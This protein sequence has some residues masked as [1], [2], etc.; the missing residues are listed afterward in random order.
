[1][2]DRD[3]DV[4]VGRRLCEVVSRDDGH[5]SRGGWGWVGYG[6]YGNVSMEGAVCGVSVSY[7]T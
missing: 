7:D 3:L 1:M 4:N 6:Y 5:G 2:R